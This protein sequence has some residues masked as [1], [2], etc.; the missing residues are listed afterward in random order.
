MKEKYVK[1]SKRQGLVLFF[2][3]N[4]DLYVY[5]NDCNILILTMYIALS[6]D[7]YCPKNPRVHQYTPTKAPGIVLPVT[8]ERIQHTA[9]R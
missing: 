1:I 5:S 3:R 9:A 7:N 8:V 4:N 2:L 6:D